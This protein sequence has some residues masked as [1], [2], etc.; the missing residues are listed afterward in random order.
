MDLELDFDA[1]CI[2]YFSKHRFVLF[3]FIG[4][5]TSKSVAVTISVGFRAPNFKSL[6]TALLGHICSQIPTENAFYH[7]NHNHS[8]NDISSIP[9]AISTAATVGNSCTSGD[10]PGKIADDAVHSIRTTIESMV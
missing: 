3:Y 8:N 5:T 10:G 7:D 1:I 2:I 6:T 9:Y 4:V